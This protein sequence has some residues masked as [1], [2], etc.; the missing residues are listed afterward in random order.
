MRIHGI[1]IV[2]SLVAAAALV[3][4]GALAIPAAS[5]APAA[6][7][8][9]RTALVGT[10]EGTY[11]GYA[12]GTYESGYERFVITAMRGPNAKGTWQYRHQESDPW[13]DPLPVQFVVKP[14]PQGGWTVTGADVNGIY[15]GTM[16]AA[17][18]RLNLAYQGS[19]NDLVS[20]SFDMRKQ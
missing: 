5:A 13:S 12:S 8:T 18:T 4:P 14:A 19:V 17:G 15:V 20:Y 3:L 6:A 9:A 1:R 2:T 11:A 16:N 10:W 7:A